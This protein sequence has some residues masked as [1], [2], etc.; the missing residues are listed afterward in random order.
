MSCR[1]IVLA[2]SVAGLDQRSAVG[3]DIPADTGVLGFHLL[4]D[5]LQGFIHHAA[6]LGNGIIV[7]PGSFD[8]LLGEII[9][10]SKLCHLLVRIISCSNH[11]LGKLIAL[12]PQF[13]LFELCIG[14]HLVT[15][16]CVHLLALLVPALRIVFVFRICIAVDRVKD[17]V[18]LV[19]VK[20]GVFIVKSLV[21]H[22]LGILP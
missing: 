22:I 21:N 12:K 2:T 8:L 6:H 1:D 19:S 13:F 17:H 11:F 14:L 3:M 9:R 5:A 20:T 15:F 7:V 18:V 4:V 10:R 16:D